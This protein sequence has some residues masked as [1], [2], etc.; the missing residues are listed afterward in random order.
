MKKTESGE[1]LKE[2]YIIE[3]DI[4]KVSKKEIECKYKYN[5]R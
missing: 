3:E 5:A 4:W 1:K 2:T